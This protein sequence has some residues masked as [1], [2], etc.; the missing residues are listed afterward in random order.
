M[1]ELIRTA[2][3]KADKTRRSLSGEN[4]KVPIECAAD[5]KIAF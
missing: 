3:I 4:F 1:A 5:M 2:V